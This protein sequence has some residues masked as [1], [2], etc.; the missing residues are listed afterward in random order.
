MGGVWQE[1]ACGA[2]CSDGVVGAACRPDRATTRYAN[3][4][5]FEFRGI[6]QDFRDWSADTYSA[7]ARGFLVAAFADGELLATA[8]TGDDGAFEID[9]VPPED[10][11]TAT[12]TSCWR[13]RASTTTARSSTR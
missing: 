12:T 2:G 8:L 7:P 4:A 5:T 10:E 13:R 3:R 6:G 1:S 9:A 11:A